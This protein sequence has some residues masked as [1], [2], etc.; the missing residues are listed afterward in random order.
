MKKIHAHLQN[1]LKDLTKNVGGNVVK[2]I[3]GKQLLQ[4]EL[5]GMAV[6]I[7]QVDMLFLKIVY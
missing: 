7:V 1:S 4:L 6:L 5:K 3:H 2:V